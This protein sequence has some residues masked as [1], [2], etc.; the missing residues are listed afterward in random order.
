MPAPDR[1]PAV[2]PRPDR[3][4]RL[5]PLVLCLLLALVAAAVPA[6]AAPRAP[7]VY[8][9]AVERLSPYQGQHLCSPAAKPGVVAFRDLLLRTYPRTRNLGISRACSVGGRS[10][11]KEGRAFDWGVHVNR[12]AEKAA[13]DDMLR[14]LLATDK[15][16]NRHANARRLGVQYV[17]WN[18]R[19][20]SSYAPTWRAYGGPNPHTDHVH[21]S[22]N[23]PGANKQTSFWSGRVVNVTAANTPTRPPVSAAPAP[24]KQPAPVPSPPAARDLQTWAVDARRA[25][26]SASP[27]SIVA[28]QQYL[29]TVTGVW[30]PAPHTQADARCWLPRGGRWSGTGPSGDLGDVLV[31]DKDIELRPVTPSAGDRRCDVTGHAYTAVVTPRRTGVVTLRVLD[32]SYADNAGSLTARLVRWTPS[33]EE[34]RDKDDEDKASEP[35]TEIAPEP[36]GP[37]QVFVPSTAGSGAATSRAYRAGTQ[38]LLRVTGTYAYGPRMHA[39]AEC[40]A[41]PSDR[42]WR[43]VSEWDPE[44]LGHLD[45]TVN[46]K[47]LP[48]TPFNT[49]RVDCDSRHEY[50]L[51]ATLSTSG[52]LRFAV[53][54]DDRRDN[55]GG[56]K[57]VVEVVR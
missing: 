2:T 24:A 17:I 32:S 23:W 26:G 38:V 11:H 20:W 3:R 36:E 56:L 33:K 18:K 30:A 31:N 57:V 8:A 47:V 13:A 52:P 54:D 35:V 55:S 44:G 50:F 48:W 49:P 14:W 29:L 15:H 46:G 27:G 10:E 21:V 51:R 42:I 6:A 12:P 9:A 40:S 34:K 45:L 53:R 43:A 25:S 37:E 19:I 22:F 4:T 16:G 28:G 39:D 41:W 1:M 5:R 7:R